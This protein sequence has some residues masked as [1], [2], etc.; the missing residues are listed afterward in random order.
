MNDFWNGFEKQADLFGGL[1]KGLSSMSKAKKSPKWGANV[2]PKTTPK[3]GDNPTLRNVTFANIPS[4]PRF[5]DI[6]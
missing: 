1:K 6:K 5:S 4:R 3:M 2:K